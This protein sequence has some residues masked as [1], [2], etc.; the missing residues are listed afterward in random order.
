MVEMHNW[1]AK[2]VTLCCNKSIFTLLRIEG[3]MLLF[4]VHS[5]VQ[6]Q[7]A[8]VIPLTISSCFVNLS[9]NP[10]SQ[11]LKDVDEFAGDNIIL[12]GDPTQILS[13]LI[14]TRL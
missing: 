6:T 3:S 12:H 14:F 13:Y 11:S 5:I 8:H 9:I 1:F 10:R 4:R 7:A 2:L